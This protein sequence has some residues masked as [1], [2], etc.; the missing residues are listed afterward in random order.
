MN[1]LYWVCLHFVI[2]ILTTKIWGKETDGSVLAVNPY[3][4]HY[5]GTNIYLDVAKLKE[6]DSHQYIT[7]L[8]TDSG[9][10]RDDNKLDYYIRYSVIS[11]GLCFYDDQEKVKEISKK[12]ELY[13]IVSVMDNTVKSDGYLRYEKTV[14]CY[15][16]YSKYLHTKSIDALKKHEICCNQ[17]VYY[18][19]GINSY[20]FNPITCPLPNFDTMKNP[21]EDISDPAQKEAYINDL[22]IQFLNELG[23]LCNNLCEEQK[24]N[25]RSCADVHNKEVTLCGYSD[26]EKKNLYCSSTDDECCSLKYKS[27]KFKIVSTLEPLPIIIGSA[28][29]AIFFVIGIFFS[30]KFIKDIKIQESIKKSIMNQE[31]EYQIANQKL[32]QNAYN[33]GYNPNDQV[34]NSRSRLLSTG[35]T[36]TLRSTRTMNSYASSSRTVNSYASSS[37]TVNSYAS[38]SR[39]MNGYASSSR[40]GTIRSNRS[41]INRYP[42]NCYNIVQDYNS[43]DARDVSLRRGMVVQLLQRYE[44]G[45]VMLKDINNNRQGYA[46]EYCLGGK[47]S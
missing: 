40:S 30:T 4:D 43:S 9:Y 21:A 45:W 10:F 28:T 36:G 20:I 46:P 5:N 37:K 13:E 14:N 11:R 3:C 17:C 19:E 8:F 12:N 32:L 1:N 23:T 2:L 15:Y 44:G 24:T 29:A 25:P 35:T 22:K 39:T 38:S 26:L 41:T 27:E 6:L 34:F 7:S 16:Y 47:M 42:P 33:E 18:Y 31:K